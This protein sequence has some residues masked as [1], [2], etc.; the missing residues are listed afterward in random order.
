MS[1]GSE[2]SLK[3]AD[4]EKGATGHT[5]ATSPKVQIV[6]AD[7]GVRRDGGILGKIPHSYPIHAPQL[8]SAA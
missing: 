4:E 2:G 1:T 6:A 3:F 8:Q 5:N 7:D